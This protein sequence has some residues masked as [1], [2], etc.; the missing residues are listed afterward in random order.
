VT[1]RQY[2][3]DYNGHVNAVVYHQWADHAR[4]EHLHRAGITVDELVENKLGPVL[5]EATIRYVG[6]L[7]MGDDVRI[8]VEPTYGD[9]RTWRVKHRFTRGDGELAAEIDAVLGLLDH[10]TRRLAGKPQQVMQSLA[11]HPD[12]V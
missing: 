5:L 8:S 3:T 12:L 11:S 4:V 10:S 7:R 6:E 2:E 1:P 9:G